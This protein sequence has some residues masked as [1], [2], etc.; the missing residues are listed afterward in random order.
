ML[1]EELSRRRAPRLAV[2][3]QATLRGRTPKEVV[4]VDLSLTGCLVRSQKPLDP[5]SIHDLELLLPETGLS[6]KARV[7]ETSRDGAATDLYL[8]GLEF[9]RLSA[10]DAKSLREFL[11]VETRRRAPAR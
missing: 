9:V 3:L 8:V 6:A 4:L 2:S 5:G 11:E 1:R 10:R 7:T